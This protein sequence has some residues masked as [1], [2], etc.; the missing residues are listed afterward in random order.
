MPCTASKDRRQAFSPAPVSKTA[1]MALEVAQLPAPKSPALLPPA[2]P[3]RLCCPPVF[4]TLLGCPFR[5]LRNTQREVRYQT[6]RC[7]LL[8]QTASLAPLPGR[9]ILAGASQG[10]RALADPAEC[11]AVREGE[12]TTIV[13][14]KLTVMTSI[15][16]GYIMMCHQCPCPD[17][18]QLL[19]AAVV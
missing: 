18:P 13:A 4:Q 5:C 10:Q 2:R 16:A 14:E 6:H 8:A 11:V 12:V 17:C 15:E 7:P 3:R 1:A 19:A 9:V